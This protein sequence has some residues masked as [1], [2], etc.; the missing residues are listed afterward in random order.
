VTEGSVLPA[1]GL[2]LAMSIIVG[3]S[4]REYNVAQQHIE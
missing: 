2:T 3:L 1:F 4:L